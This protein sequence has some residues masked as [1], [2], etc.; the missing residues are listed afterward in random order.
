VTAIEGKVARNVLVIHRRLQ[1]SP[2]LRDLARYLAEVFKDTPAVGPV[3]GRSSF[4][5]ALA[6]MLGCSQLEAEKHVDQLVASKHL[7]FEGNQGEPGVWHV[8][9]D[10]DLTR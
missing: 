10:A 3:V 2:S 6:G 4:R 5:D 9:P 7:V 1:M 8:R